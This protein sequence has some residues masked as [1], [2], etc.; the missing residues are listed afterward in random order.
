MEVKELI[1]YYI[2]EVSQTL[3]VTFRTLLDADDEIR[4]DQ[5]EFSEIKHFGYEM[6]LSKV[7]EFKDLIDEDSEYFDEF[8]KLFEDEDLEYDVI[9]FLNEY[10]LINTDK[11]PPSE[12]F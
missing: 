7:D 4:T 11:L 9:S 8:D 6:L 12:L 1:T 3:D 10:Y 5:I 2:N